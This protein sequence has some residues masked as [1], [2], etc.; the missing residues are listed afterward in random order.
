LQYSLVL[1]SSFS[2]QLATRH[3]YHKLPTFRLLFASRP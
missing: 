1:V 2:L 3:N